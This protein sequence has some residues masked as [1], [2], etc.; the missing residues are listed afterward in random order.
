VRHVHRPGRFDSIYHPDDIAYTS[1]ELQALRDTAAHF[2]ETAM[3]WQTLPILLVILAAGCDPQEFPA[4][5]HNIMNA[6]GPMTA[7]RLADGTV[8][9][10]STT[11]KDDHPELLAFTKGSPSQ[12][13]LWFD[14]SPSRCD[15]LGPSGTV[16]NYSFC[17]NLY[18]IT[19]TPGRDR[20]YA[21]RASGTFAV[22]PADMIP[23]GDGT[24]PE[25]A[26]KYRY[27]DAARP[28]FG[29][30]PQY[31]E[32]PGCSGVTW[33]LLWPKMHLPLNSSGRVQSAT[34]DVI[35]QINN[36]SITIGRVTIAP[37]AQLLVVP[38]H[39]HWWA[40][41]T[42][43]SE[44]KSI[45]YSFTETYDDPG[46]VRTVYDTTDQAFASLT[47]PIGSSLHAPTHE[48]AFTKCNVQLRLSSV[49]F[50]PKPS[51]LLV[52]GRTVANI[53]TGTCAGFLQD[54]QDV[55]PGVTK[56]PIGAELRRFF[57]NLPDG[58]PQGVHVAIVDRVEDRDGNGGQL[59][60]ERGL[61]C[62]GTGTGNAFTIVE[63]SANSLQIHEV[64]HALGLGEPGV[65]RLLNN[66]IT[67]ADCSTV[68]TEAQRIINLA[69]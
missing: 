56:S 4:G 5:I 42:N 9:Y 58:V 12:W 28:A 24:A 23:I 66:T 13:M 21:Q 53:S 6:A 25:A 7:T 14:G 38:I 44:R 39:V 64:G 37:S 33:P 11:S 60:G 3:R 32:L 20:L 46:A 43:L 51:S 26:F 63:N 18:G 65:T 52:N 47:R 50:H 49:Q 35:Q 17:D 36:V 27:V 8:L 62:V 29:A 54:A 48:N 10:W 68:R 16:P 34:V 30:L 19:N 40:N 22:F 67:T 45:A 41:G 59:Q 69:D 15:P 55:A 61:G 57:V 2:E 1:L 31:C